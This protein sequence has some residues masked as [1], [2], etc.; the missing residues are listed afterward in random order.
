MSFHDSLCRREFFDL[1]VLCPVAPSLLSCPLLLPFV[2]IGC[3]EF[4][5][6]FAGDAPFT[7]DSASREYWFRPR[8]P[9]DFCGGRPPR[10]GAGVG[11]ENSIGASGGAVAEVMA[12]AAGSSVGVGVASEGSGSASLSVEHTFVLPSLTYRLPSYV[13]RVLCVC[14]LPRYVPVRALSRVALSLVDFLR[15]HR[16]VSALVQRLLCYRPLI[17]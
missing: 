17:Q 14:W 2:P 16:A 8:R 3:G 15:L 6:S 1:I 13:Q 9:R 12:V 11:F 5:M 4:T 7:A 10:R